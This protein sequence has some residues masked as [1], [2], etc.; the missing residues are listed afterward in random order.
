MRSETVTP[1]QVT[2]ICR[3][4]I[5]ANFRETGVCGA[6]L[7]LDES[8]YKALEGSP[9]FAIVAFNGDDQPVGLVSVFVSRHQHTCELIATNDTLYCTPAYRKVG[10]GGK[11]FRLAEQEAKRRGANILAS[12]WEA[13]FFWRWRPSSRHCTRNLPAGVLAML[14]I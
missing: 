5:E 12:A 1:L 14:A 7:R 13:K 9:S 11:L 8:L 10:L 3:E 6:E 4:L 2:R